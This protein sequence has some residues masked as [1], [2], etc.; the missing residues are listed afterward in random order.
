MAKIYSK[1]QVQFPWPLGSVNPY[2]LTHR[3]ARI[4]I[5]RIAYWWNWD[6]TRVP[7]RHAYPFIA[8]WAKALGLH[9][10]WREW[11][12]RRWVHWR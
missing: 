2:R 4:M 11:E 5:P 8:L 9:E 1:M 10:W 12:G 3:Q 6:R 7:L